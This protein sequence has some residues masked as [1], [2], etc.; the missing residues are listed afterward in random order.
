M[1][2]ITSKRDKEMIVHV[3]QQFYMRKD[4]VHHVIMVQ[5][6][7][8]ELQYIYAHFNFSIPQ[9]IDAKVVRWFGDDAKF[10]AGNF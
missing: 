5:A 10:I 7:D 2:T 9:V 6:D 3:G 1:L 8:D 4:D